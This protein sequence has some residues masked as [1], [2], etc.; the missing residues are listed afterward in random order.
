MLRN[1]SLDEEYIAALKQELIAL[2]ASVAPQSRRAVSEVVRVSARAHAARFYTVMLEQPNARFYLD[3]ETVSR[4]L[5]AS[6]ASWLVGIFSAEPLDIERTFASLLDIGAIHARIQIP[7]LLIMKGFREIKAAIVERLGQIRL[8]Q[9]DGA[10]AIRFVSN[11]IDLALAV[12]MVA[13]MQASER[14]VRS[15]EVFRLFALGKDLAAERERQR[16]ALAEW[17][18]QIF[19]E[20]QTSFGAPNVV[21]LGQSDFGLWFLHRANL[22]FSHSGEYEAIATAIDKVDSLIERLSA[23]PPPAERVSTILSIKV[24]V[25]RIGSL[26]TML[27]DQSAETDRTRD[28]L[29][30]LLNKRFLTTVLLREI[31]IQKAQRRPFSLVLF[32]INKLDQITRELGHAGADSVIQQT[33]SMLFNV[34]RT[35]DSVFRMGQGTFLIIRVEADVRKAST[36]ASSVAERYAATHFTMEGAPFFDN[37]LTF[38]VVE[39]DGHPDP[40]HTIIRAERALRERNPGG[41]AS[42]A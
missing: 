26:L 35:G 24:M 33:A 29:T 32:E 28:P 10:D 17:A 40:R 36:F 16:A 30:R 2:N 39:Y 14:S 27:F 7:V 31:E 23:D 11:L 19:Y 41:S 34:A 21:P 18:Q 37:S 13:Y 6:L 9:V 25:D 38:A 4:R 3:Q 20:M 5:H 12:M 8:E 22:F 15:D 1:N 42:V